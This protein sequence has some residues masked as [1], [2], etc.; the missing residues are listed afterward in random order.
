MSSPLVSVVIRTKD[1]PHFLQGALEGV[2]AQE[3]RDFE[4]IVVN[5][6]GADVTGVIEPFLDS[7]RVRHVDVQP[8]IGRCAAGNRGIEEAR[9][10]YI[11]WLDDDDLY[12]PN[13]LSTLTGLLERGEYLAAYSDA[14]EARQVLREDGSYEVVERRLVLKNDF[15]PVRFF[16]HVPFHLVSFMHRRE[17]VEKLGGFDES[18]EVLE[19]WDLFFRLSQD[20]TF[21]RIPVVTAEYRIRDDASQAITTMREEFLRTR[22]SLFQKY[23]HTAV[24]AFVEMYFEQRDGLAEMRERVAELTGEID[25]LRGELN[26]L[27]RGPASSDSSEAGEPGPGSEAGATGS[28]GPD[29]ERDSAPEPEPAPARGGRRKRPGFFRSR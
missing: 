19:D 4:C 16:Q 8:S 6:G 14:Y 29:F 25:R 9:G 11:S 24:P 13:H 10:K 20:Y 26:H 5:D 12:Y 2:A 15:H 17:C 21:H 18:L 3:F 22:E 23:F 7:A 27:R 1:R 28:G